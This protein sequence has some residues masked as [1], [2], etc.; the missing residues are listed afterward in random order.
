MEIN[1]PG[2]QGQRLQFNS[3]YRWLVGSSFSGSP[4]SEEVRKL[5]YRKDAFPVQPIH[6]LRSHAVQEGQV[7]FFFSLLAATSTEWANLAVIV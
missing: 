5:I 6:D 2:A 3:E 4:W 1:L 7:V